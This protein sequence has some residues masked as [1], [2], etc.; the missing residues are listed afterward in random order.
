[1]L[2]NA[3]AE[4]QRE[5]EELDH[6]LSEHCAR[7]ERA[8]FEQGYPGLKAHKEEHAAYALEVERARRNGV[9]PAGIAFMRAWLVN[10]IAESERQHQEWLAENGNNGDPPRRHARG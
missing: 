5:I 4:L 2:R 10:H 6:R 7:E 3:P 9:G 1:M 8:L